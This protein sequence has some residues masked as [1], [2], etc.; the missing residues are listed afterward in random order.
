MSLS[1]IL[2]ELDDPDFDDIHGDDETGGFAADKGLRLL[3]ASLYAGWRP[4]SG[5]GF[6]A[7]VRVAV[8]DGGRG[9]SATTVTPDL[10]LAHGTAPAEAW[11]QPAHRAYSLPRFGKPPDMVLDLL[12]SPSRSEAYAAR[13]QAY[14]RFGVTYRVVYDPCRLFS[15]RPVTVFERQGGRLTPRTDMQLPQLGLGLT[16][17]RGVFEGRDDTWLRWIDA[18]GELLLTGEESADLWR[19]RAPAADRQAASGDA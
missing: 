6:L 10:L 15:D 11:W 17:R 1:Y 2:Q 5:G 4:A 13:H 3:V 19:R 8:T 7:A 18:D 9:A 14:E 16:L 12:A